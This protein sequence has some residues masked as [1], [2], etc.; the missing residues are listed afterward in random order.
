MEI[1]VT[2]RDVEKKEQNFGFRVINAGKTFVS[3]EAFN[4]K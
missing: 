4:Y 3:D 2:K 1:E